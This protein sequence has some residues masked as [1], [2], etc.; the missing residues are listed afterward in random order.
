MTK[1]IR[2]AGP[3]NAVAESRRRDRS[4]VMTLSLE[5]GGVQKQSFHF[6]DGRGGKLTKRADFRTTRDRAAKLFPQR[7]R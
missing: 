6:V 3:V 2:N 1:A 7:I 5:Y 4:F